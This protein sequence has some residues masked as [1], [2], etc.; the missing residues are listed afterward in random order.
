LGSS[1]KRNDQLGLDQIAENGAQMENFAVQHPADYANWRRHKLNSPPAAADALRVHIENPTQL[2]A[3]ELAALQAACRRH[4]F[5]L[6]RL[7]RPAADP[8][9]ALP[10]LGRQ[11]GLRRLDHNLCAEDSGL[12]ALRANDQPGGARYIPYTNRPL[13]WHT[14]GYYNPPERQ[15]RAWLL[16]CAQDAA[17]G[18][19]SAVLDHEIAYIRLRDHDPALAEAL[20]APDS[21]TIPANEADGAELR[22]AQSGPVFSYMKD[23]GRL[24]MRY[25]ARQRNVAWKDDPAVRAAA[26]FLLQLFSD[27]DDHIFQYRLQPGEGLIS[28][29][30]LHR[31]TGFRDDPA[32]GRQRLF[33]RARY[34]DRV[35]HT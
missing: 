29:N 22:A 33:Y 21:F 26:A 18:G 8:Q 35:A 14:D 10:A 20:M 4:N 16:Y 9:A 19:E 31:R 32:T 11:L 2:T 24:H 17:E 1:T 30:A 12:S 23:S 3:G 5:A 34:Y 27:G 25:S 13:S 28:N 7:A 6:F 15:I